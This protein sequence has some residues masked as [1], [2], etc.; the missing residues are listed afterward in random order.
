VNTVHDGWRDLE[1]LAR[2]DF[3]RFSGQVDSEPPGEDVEELSRAVVKVV[4]FSTTRWDAF[5]DHGQFRS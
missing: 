4:H 3:D 1:G 2:A 5:F